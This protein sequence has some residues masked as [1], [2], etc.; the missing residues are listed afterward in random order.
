MTIVDQLIAFVR[1]ETFVAESTLT[2]FYIAC[3]VMI[4]VAAWYFLM[5]VIRRYAAIIR[6]YQAKRYSWFVAVL[7]WLVRRF[8]L[9]REAIDRK[10]SWGTLDRG[11]KTKFL[12]LYLLVVVF[13]E[14]FLRLTFEYLIAF[15]QMHEAI[16]RGAL[17][18]AATDLR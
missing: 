1:F 2:L 12:A 17:E 6:L 13:A 14:I 8:R 18:L 4:P 15:M 5:W 10:I 11:Q 16:T 7:V 9:V 3:A